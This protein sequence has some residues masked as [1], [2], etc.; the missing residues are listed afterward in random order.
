[1]EIAVPVLPFPLQGLGNAYIS[2]LRLAWISCQR[3]RHDEEKF[4]SRTSLSGESPKIWQ[5]A[6]RRLEVL[7]GQGGGWHLILWHLHSLPAHGPSPSAPSKCPHLGHRL[8]LQ[9]SVFLP[10]SLGI[11]TLWALHTW[12]SRG[13]S[14]QLRCLLFPSLIHEWSLLTWALRHWLY[15]MGLQYSGLMFQY[16]SLYIPAL[17]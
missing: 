15:Y 5:G 3:V 13:S 12:S 4:C 8:G 7:T 1:M 2:I 10:S 9:N 17:K 11:A 16:H 6:Q 14:S